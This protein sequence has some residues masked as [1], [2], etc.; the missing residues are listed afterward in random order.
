MF[1]FQFSFLPLLLPRAT[2]RRSRMGRKKN[3]DKRKT[4]LIKVRFDLIRIRTRCLP[5]S[6]HSFRF[7]LLLVR[8][9]AIQYAQRSERALRK[10]INAKLIF[11]IQRNGSEF[12]ASEFSYI[13]SLADDSEWALRSG[14]AHTL[15]TC[16][17]LER[18]CRQSGMTDS[19]ELALIHFPVQRR[20]KKK[21]IE[22]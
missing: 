19:V 15:I 1:A 20:V 13:S 16:F 17:L 7:H 22:E 14:V 18:L 5:I 10:M 2:V 6:T 21:P 9:A 12:G 3:S 8:A 4:A 11:G